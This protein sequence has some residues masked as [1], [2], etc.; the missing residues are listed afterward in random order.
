MRAKRNMQK[1]VIG[2]GSNLGV[3]EAHLKVACES[4]ERVLGELR[5]SPLYESPAH[6]PENAPKSWDMPFLNM[7]V[8]GV[9]ELEPKRLLAEMKSIEQHLGRVYRGGW[10]PREIDLDILAM[11]DSVVDIP[12]LNVPHKLLLERDFAL[13]PLADVWP[14]WKCPVAGE[15]FGKT[16]RE[17]ADAL[18]PEAKRTARRIEAE[19]VM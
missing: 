14:E 16:A 13:L 1:I 19:T 15:H 12:G 2:L 4:L 6:L 18:F 8:S 5:K 11:G 9:Y 3:R 17:L 10:G 7:A